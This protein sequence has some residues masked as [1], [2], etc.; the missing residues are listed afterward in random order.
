MFIF[1]IKKKE[2]ICLHSHTQTLKAHLALVTEVLF[3]VLI[4]CAQRLETVVAMPT[5]GALDTAR[6]A[7]P[8][9][10]PGSCAVWLG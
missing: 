3:K 10:L 7:P 8:V 5:C 6:P 1:K 4:A 9:G 2:K